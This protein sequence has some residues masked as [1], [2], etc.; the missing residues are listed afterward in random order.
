MKTDIVKVCVLRYTSVCG[1]IEWSE[2][3]GGDDVGWL[4]LAHLLVGNSSS[5]H[6]ALSV[7][8]RLDIGRSKGVSVGTWSN[9][10]ADGNQGKK[11]LR[12]SSRP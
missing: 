8:N 6:V 11:I 9:T 12:S 2:I 5:H 1:S 4:S 10:Y 7:V 3:A